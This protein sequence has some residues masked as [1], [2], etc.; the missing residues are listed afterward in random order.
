[1][2]PPAEAGRGDSGPSITVQPWDPKT[3]YMVA[4]KAAAKKG[5]AYETYL[6]QRPG[7]AS[8]PSYYLD[9][10]SYF[11][12]SG[13]QALGRRILSSILDLELDDPS[14]LRVVGYRLGET[15]DLDLAIVVLEQVLELRPEEPQSYRDLALILAQ[16]AEG[17][18]RVAAA[19]TEQLIADMS[20]S[21]DL[22][23]QVV[24]GL[25][26]RRRFLGIEVIALMELNRQ[27]RVSSDLPAKLQAKIERPAL[28][29][30]FQKLLSVDIRI[31]LVWD[32]DLTDIDLWV[33]EPTGEKAY[34]SNPR[35]AIGGLVSRDFT[36]GYG[37]EEYVLR[38]AVPGTYTIRAKYYGSR[39][40]TLMG[41]VTVKAVVF[42]DYGLPT[43]KRQELTL[44]LESMKEVVTVGTIEISAD[45]APVTAGG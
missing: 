4:L 17:N 37:P 5:K 19:D 13:D 31:S 34:Y 18:D 39:Q 26:D 16:R 9:C 7:Y 23:H 6:A 30:R 15:A 22:L 42:T 20:R 35:S 36:R 27:L 33:I 2:A 41:P 29:K 10:A 32:A 43:E 12:G 44:R 25:W 38:E 14:L 1:M 11:Y 28:D 3:P 40:Q 24:T 8:S 45:R 21:M